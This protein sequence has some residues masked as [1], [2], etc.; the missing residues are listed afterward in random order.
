MFQLTRNMNVSNDDIFSFDFGDSFEIIESEPGSIYY[1]N[2]TIY[3]MCK[4]AYV[5]TVYKEL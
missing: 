5:S 4:S 2:L 1:A 3:G